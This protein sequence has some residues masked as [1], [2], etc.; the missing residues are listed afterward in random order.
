MFSKLKQDDHHN[1]IEIALMSS[2]LSMVSLTI[3]TVKWHYL[4][5]PHQCHGHKYISTVKS[6]QLQIYL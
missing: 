3:F 4:R 2:Y 5:M 1:C 6:Y